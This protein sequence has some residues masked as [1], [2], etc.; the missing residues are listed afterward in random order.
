MLFRFSIL[1]F[2][3][4]L[5]GC[6]PN[7]TRGDKGGANKK[8]DDGGDDQPDP[9]AEAE[10]GEEFV[11]PV[12]EKDYCET[13]KDSGRGNVPEYLYTAK[14]A[15]DIKPW[16]LTYKASRGD[17]QEKRQAMKN[18]EE[19]RAY[20]EDFLNRTAKIDALKPGRKFQ[21]RIMEDDEQNAY[22]DGRQN[23]VINSSFL[24]N[25]INPEHLLGILCHEMSHSLRNDAGG[26]EDYYDNVLIDDPEKNPKAKSFYDKV[27]AYFVKTYDDKTSTYTHDKA[28]F[29]AINP[30]FKDY[31]KAF[32]VFS[33]RIEATADVIGGGFCVSIGMKQIGRAHV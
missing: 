25:K 11:D 19:I 17:A 18:S 32:W 12:A 6:Q 8:P 20:M 26:L 3:L 24:K 1:A 2:A 10:G 31:K 28:A 29:D 23:I 22:A 15:C 30:A 16:A 14:E 27:D 33:K 4:C 7:T 13:L 5:G 21:I 9:S